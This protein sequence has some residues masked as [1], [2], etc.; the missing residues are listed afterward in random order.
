[1][2]NNH[3]LLLSMVSGA[4]FCLF[5]N[6]V[7]VMSS[8]AQMH[9]PVSTVYLSVWLLSECISIASYLAQQDVPNS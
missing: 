1:M 4:V 9:S 2:L 6:Q 3:A 8:N 5:F 7:A